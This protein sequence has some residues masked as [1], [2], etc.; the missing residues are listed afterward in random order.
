MDR[1]IIEKVK[2]QFGRQAERYA[3]S[4]PH[5]K[6]ASLELMVEWAEPRPTDCVLDVAT[7][8]GFTAFA[9]AARARRVV[10]TDVTANMLAQAQRLAGERGLTNLLFSL[11]EAEAI[12]FHDGTFDIA[13]CRIAPHHF[14]SVSRFLSEMRRVL[15][16]DGTLVL[17]DSSSPEEPD[18][19]AWQQETERLRDPSHVRNYSPSEWQR[20]TEEA[21]FRVGRIDTTH[22]SHLA[23]TDWVRTSGNDAATVRLLRERFLG[24][25]PGVRDAF[26][27]RFEGEEIHFSWTLTILLAQRG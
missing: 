6:G 7:G 4:R 25:P 20:M 19:S 5:A 27:I 1:E 10:A 21:G 16:S 24:A 8:T 23:F 9:F 11:A 12:P 14:I 22:R 15:R 18:A 17:C 13:T 3:G 2:A 26:Q